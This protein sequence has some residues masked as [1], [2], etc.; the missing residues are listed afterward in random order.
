M[1]KKISILIML[2]SSYLLAQ[3]INK[4]LEAQ[5]PIFE[6]VSTEHIYNY[7]NDSLDELIV[8]L[9]ETNKNI[10]I[11]HIEDYENNN[12]ITLFTKNSKDEIVKESSI[13]YAKTPFLNLKHYSSIIKKDDLPLAKLNIYYTE[14]GVKKI[15]LTQKETALLKE[16]RNLSLVF[17]NAPPYVIAENSKVEGIFPDIVD[18]IAKNL[19]LD[20]IKLSSIS[21]EHSAEM[22][23]RGEAQGIGAITL[24]KDKKSRDKNLVYS[25]SYFS[26]FLALY[27]SKN[28][29]TKIDSIDE[30]EGKK[31]SL[32]KNS[33]SASDIIETIP[34]VEI[35]LADSAEEAADLAIEGKVD[36]FLYG[37]RGL[38]QTQFDYTGHLKI[39]KIL[40]ELPINI[41]LALDK[42]YEEYIPIINKAIANI[43]ENIKN[44]IASKWLNTELANLNIL[45]PKNLSEWIERQE[46]IKIGIDTT[47]APFEFFENNEHKGIVAEIMSMVLDGINLKHRYVSTDTWS[48]LFELIKLKKID[49][50]SGVWEDS[51]KTDMLFSHPYMSFDVMIVTRN[52]SDLISNIKDLE[53]KKIAMAEG[54]YDIEKICTKE[55]G[56]DPKNIELINYDNISD[57]LYALSKGE[58]YAVL[59][60][61]AVVNYY[62]K[63]SG[64]TNLKISA[65]TD[66]RVDLRVGVS[67]DMPELLESINIALAS[68][69]EA[70]KDEI[71]RKWVS[72]KVEEQIDY[73]II[74]Q[75]VAASVALLLFIMYWNRKLVMEIRKRKETESQLRHAQQKALEASNAKSEFL[76]NMSHE[77][78]TPMNAIIGMNTLALKHIPQNS[79]SYDFV[80]KSLNSAKMLLRIINDIL[81]FS[82]I[83]AGKLEIEEIP[84]ESGHLISQINDLFGYSAASKGI[85]FSLDID[86]STPPYLRGDSLR[87][88]QVITN[89]ISNAIKFTDKGGVTL[90][91]EVLAQKNNS[92]VLRCSVIDSGKGIAKDKID[93]LFSSFSQENSEIS[94]KYGGTGLGLA[95]SKRLVEMMGGKIWC[96]SVEGVGSK[97]SFELSLDTCEAT[98]LKKSF[99][100]YS[101]QKSRIM[102]I[103]DDQIILDIVEEALK[104]FSFELV[105][106]SNPQNAL[107]T[108]KND[109]EG[110]D[111]VLIDYKLNNTNGIDLLKKINM[112]QDIPKQPKALLMSMYDLEELKDRATEIGFDGFIAKPLNQSILLDA[113]MGSITINSQNE[114]FE[115]F[116]SI[117]LEDSHI[118]LV[119]DN[120]INREV[121]INFL[122]NMVGHIDIATNGQEALDII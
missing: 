10:Q 107:S 118:L 61:M 21:Q 54:Y 121:A 66:Y 4:Q 110:F 113:I 47:W 95:I 11:I 109:K 8:D 98:D 46:S 87:I 103:D 91:L 17:E 22:I 31:I 44:D 64:I 97:F 105:L 18:I 79:E 3:N 27:N 72:L 12:T 16:M 100:T 1:I 74:W 122:K 56:C 106:E 88:M 50:I 108:I 38:P 93:T 43:D 115:H 114:D 59:E 24:I 120:D 63:K 99:G 55:I 2:L 28:S 37:S 80:K 69:S 70:K 84:F 33:I 15:H 73:T 71:Y 45:L 40:K 117:K 14:E 75:I 36:F 60:N 119:E 68:I 111:L 67:E 86:K 81:D 62:M 104:N 29:E 49:M 23:E 78:R 6:K 25:D 34:G 76:A 96:E 51:K 94:R 85:E 77:I 101:V 5:L 58:C 20:I 30:L 65:K 89:L 13:E 112:L 7:D 92:V 102:V 116:Q 90:K 82:K 35:V 19:N 48:D 32:V 26:G 83:E 41:S 57:A 53:G 9:L 42:K 39:A 52:D